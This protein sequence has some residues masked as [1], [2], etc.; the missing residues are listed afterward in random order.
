MIVDVSLFI[1]Y[2]LKNKFQFEEEGIAIIFLLDFRSRC[3]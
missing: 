3:S 2:N 1:Q